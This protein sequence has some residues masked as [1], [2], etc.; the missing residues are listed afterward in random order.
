M[1]SIL[2]PIIRQNHVGFL[3][4]VSDYVAVRGAWG[5]RKLVRGYSGSAIRVRRSSDN[6]ETDIGYIGKSLDTATL[7]S[8]V[9][10]GDGFVKTIYDQ[11]GNGKDFVQATTSAQGKIVSS[12]SYLG[13]VQGDGV[14]SKMSA[15]GFGSGTNQVVSLFGRYAIAD[16]ASGAQAY[17]LDCA[18]YQG[19]TVNG[20]AIVN[21]GRSAVVTKGYSVN[22]SAGT[23]YNASGSYPAGVGSVS[24]ISTLINSGYSA[25]R[26]LY[27]NGS[28][29]TFTG[30]D[31]HQPSQFTFTTNT[32]ILGDYSTGGSIA[33]WKLESIVA[34]EADAMSAR[35]NVEAAL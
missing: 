4:F 8:Y 21:D 1:S 15:T 32:L 3:S 30:S 2:L 14:N 31:F 7:L 24:T 25:G 5:I 17:F 27:V 10:A 9:G 18:Y 11:S 33:S 34:V 19:G 16:P 6:A 13:Y 35:T 20:W 28:S 29:R 22:A 23:T 12:G 26:A